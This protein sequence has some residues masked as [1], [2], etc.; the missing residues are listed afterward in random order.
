[1][2]WSVAPHIS[3]L[4]AVE[5]GFETGEG[6]FGVKWATANATA[7]RVGSQIFTVDIET[8][9]HTSGIVKIPVLGLGVHFDAVSRRYSGAEL[10]LD[11]RKVDT[12]NIETVKGIP[13]L[14]VKG[15]KHTIAVVKLDH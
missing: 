13:A 9:P 2:T 7:R 14:E 5:G 4:D 8:P 12:V 10:R 1:M 6:W 3:G 15:G 11:G